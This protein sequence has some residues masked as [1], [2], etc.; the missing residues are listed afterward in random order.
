M[1][2]LKY[3]AAFLAAVLV[4]GAC[5]KGDGL[6][7]QNKD[8]EKPYVTLSQKVADDVTLTFEITASE[9]AKHY[10]YAVFAGSDNAVPAAYDILVGETSGA[11]DGAFTVGEDKKYTQTVTVDCSAFPSETYQI[12]AAAMTETGLLSEVLTLDVTMNDTLIPEPAG[13]DIDGNTITLAFDELIARGKGKAYV[14]V[15]AWGVGKVYINNQVIAE[16]NITIE[17]NT[18]TIVCPEAGNG[19]GYILSFEEG[20]V[21]DLSGNPCEACKSGLDENSEY[22]GLGWDTE[23]VNFNIT[24][25]SFE[26]PAE[27]TD[28]AAEDASLTFKFPVQVM[29]AKAVN[30]IKVIYK[31]AEGI[32]QLNAEYVLAEDAQ[33]VTVY[34]PKMPT[35]EFDVSVDANAF[36]DMWGNTNNA[37]SPEGYRYSNFLIELVAGNYLVEYLYPDAEGNPVLDEFPLELEMVDKTTVV[38][39]ADWFNYMYNQYGMSGY[40]AAPYLIG[41]VNYAKQTIVFDGRYLDSKGNLSQYNA[42][43]GGFYYYDADQTM[44]TVFWGG[45]A[46]GSDPVVVTF[47]EDGYLDSMSY[48]DYSVY[49]V[50]GGYLALYGCTAVTETA[51]AAMTYVPAEDDTV[52]ANAP[53]KNLVEP[54]YVHGN[55]RK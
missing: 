51:N 42:F 23:W 16:E 41:T 36:Y 10:A 35:G 11:D 14:S 37:F 43:G 6:S 54:V 13:A 31:E 22:V 9:D 27:D 46:D 21:T 55:F 19:A 52:S 3:F 15:I 1:K 45:G 34:L 7:Q 17:A 25:D 5:D 18:V 49:K 40:A 38:V 24:E 29:D 39:Y 26:T 8:K 53:A 2:T 47:N 50:S 28:W 30:P 12:F 44:M 48:C 20:L 4:L 33:T 32:Y